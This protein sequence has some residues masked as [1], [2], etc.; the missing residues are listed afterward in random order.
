MGNTHG[1]RPRRLDS[2]L[3]STSHSGKLT[4]VVRGGFLPVEGE[5]LKW[6]ASVALLSEEI[7]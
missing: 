1:K 5:N 3:D 6:G 7:S 2:F 4:A